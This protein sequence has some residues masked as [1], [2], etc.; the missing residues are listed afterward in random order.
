[1]GVFH[2]V[3]IWLFSWSCRLF[4]ELESSQTSTSTRKREMALCCCSW[5]VLRGFI[6]MHNDR[7]DTKDKSMTVF[8]HILEVRRKDTNV[9]ICHHIA[10][11][12]LITFSLG[13]RFWQIGCLVLFCHDI[14]D[15][16]LDASKIFVYIQNRP[17]ASNSTKI[18][19][20]VVK[21]LG[22]VCFVLSWILFRFHFYPRKA[23]YSVIYH[24]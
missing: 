11:I 5:M 2:C 15:I 3:Q 24:R 20:E 19:C 14:C 1:M 21:T 10:T 23:L 8:N 17:G 6:S 4:S 9:M 18:I 13:M 22:F 16:F 7:F 12:F